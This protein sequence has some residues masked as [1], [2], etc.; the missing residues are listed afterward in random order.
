M[1][2]LSSWNDEDA[3]ED[4]TIASCTAYLVMEQCDGS[5]KQLLEMGKVFMEGEVA[6]LVRQ[7]V[8]ALEYI[9]DKGVMHR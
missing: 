3:G 1:L 5:L 2:V 6:I 9:H 7:V 8:F 4:M